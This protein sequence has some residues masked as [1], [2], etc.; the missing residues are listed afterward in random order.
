MTPRLTMIMITHLFLVSNYPL[1]QHRQSLI[2]EATVLNHERVRVDPRSDVIKLKSIIYKQ[3][4]MPPVKVLEVVCEGDDVMDG[5]L[6]LHDV[7]LL[8]ARGRQQVDL[9]HPRLVNTVKEGY[10]R[11]YE[12]ICI[13]KIVQRR[14][15]FT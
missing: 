12:S 10:R 8:L 3:F 2:V 15:V 4:S 9:L 11:I 13:G 6:G 14:I 1:P 5:H 7:D